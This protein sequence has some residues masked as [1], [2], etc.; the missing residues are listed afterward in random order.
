MIQYCATDAKTGKLALKPRIF[1]NAAA[2][3]WDVWDDQSFL[4]IVII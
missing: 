2:E 3:L 4:T 1:F